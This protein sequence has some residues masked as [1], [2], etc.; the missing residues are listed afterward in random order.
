MFDLAREAKA[1]RAAESALKRPVPR[2]PEAAFGNRV[3]PDTAGAGP[4]AGAALETQTRAYFEPRFGVDLSSVRVHHDQEAQRAAAALDADAFTVGSHI[5]FASGRYSPYSDAGRRLLAHELAHVVEQR[6]SG[7][8]VDCQKGGAAPTEAEKKPNNQLLAD[9]PDLLMAPGES[10]TFDRLKKVAITMGVRVAADP[11]PNAD[12]QAVYDPVNNAVWI[13]EKEFRKRT[14]DPELKRSITHELVHAVQRRSVVE[15]SKDPAA[16]MA[17]IEKQALTMTED[18]YV[19]A[20]W[21]AEVDAES[22]AWTVH[23]ESID[24]FDRRRGGSGFSAEDLA[25]ITAERV[26]EFSEQSRKKYDVKF[27]EAYRSLRA[28]AR[29]RD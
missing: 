6:S 22:T 18:E 28:R 27:R 20:R 21:K 10:P 23:G 15:A 9:R 7:I 4:A 13:P 19:E 14:H 11:N 2:R 29:T 12:D 24:R 16:R 25:E 1:D 17:A 5:S 8:A 26:R 3:A